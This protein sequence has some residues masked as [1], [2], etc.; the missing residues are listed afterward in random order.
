MKS[1]IKDTTDFLS[2]LPQLTDSNAILVSFD[3]ENL[4]T[5][6]PH[7]L[8]IEAIQF[9]LEKYPQELPAR[10]DKNFILEGI[11]FILENNYF[12]LNDKYFLQKKGTAMGTKFAPIFSTLVLGYLEEKL[13]A[14]LEKEF[15]CSLSNI[16]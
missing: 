1:Y 7:K 13:Y 4:Y 10:I 2:K 14:N 11:K 15:Y 6:L 9:W 5:N 3:V 16:L 8:G 12:C